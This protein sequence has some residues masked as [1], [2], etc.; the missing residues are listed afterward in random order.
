VSDVWPQLAHFK[1]PGC[2][3][4]YLLVAALAVVLWVA[5]RVEQVLVVCGT[6]SFT[7][8][9]LYKGFRAYGKWPARVRTACLGAFEQVSTP[10]PATP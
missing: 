7:R 6:E 8:E 10:F 9:L 3:H 2:W 5:W 4:N 1:L